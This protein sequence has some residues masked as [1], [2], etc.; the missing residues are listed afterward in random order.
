[1]V[2]RILPCPPLLYHLPRSKN[3]LPSLKELHFCSQSIW[4]SCLE[5]V[6]CC[7]LCQMCRQSET[8]ICTDWQRELT[9]KQKMLPRSEQDTLLFSD[10]YFGLELSWVTLLL[11]QLTKLWGYK[12]ICSVRAES[13]HCLPQ[14]QFLEN[15]FLCLHILISFG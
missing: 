14:P 13:S 10:F 1:M 5:F 3:S 6:Q 8:A 2:K 7:H 4:F 12:N 9:P 15:V 11:T